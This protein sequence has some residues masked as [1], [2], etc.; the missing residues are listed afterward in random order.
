MAWIRLDD[1]YINHPKFLNLSHQAFRLWHE[2][3]SYCR[4]SLND[5]LIP[6]DAL[7]TFRYA[8]GVYVAE[9]C[10]SVGH[11]APLWEKQ[12]FGWKVHDYLDWNPGY[13][14]EQDEREAA[15]LRMRAFRGRR[16]KDP[17]VVTVAVTRHVTPVVTRNVTYEVTPAVPGQGKDLSSLEEKERELSMRAGQ[18]IQRYRDLY[19]Q[20]RNGAR[21]RVIGSPLEFQESI[22]LCQLWDDAHLEKLAVL[23]LTTNDDFISKTDRS[24]KIFAMK[25]TWADDKLKAWEVEHGVSA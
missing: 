6:K 14:E 17:P 23:V 4:K 19:L 15:K 18:L 3:M 12:A 8:K 10:A 13:E 11:L 5:G 7:K 9:L 22:S 21:L 2:G 24:F 20:H 25:A 1:D 16:K